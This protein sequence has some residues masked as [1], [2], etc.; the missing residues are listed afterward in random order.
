MVSVH[1]KEEPRLGVRGLDPGEEWELP[2]NIAEQVQQLEKGLQN[3]SP[4]K[5]VSSF[6]LEN[7]RFKGII[8]RI[9]SLEGYEYAEIQEN[10]LS[11]DLYPL[12]LL[13]CKLS[14]FGAERFN[15]KSDKW[16]RITL[17]QGA[18]L[19]EEIGKTYLDHWV[20]PSL[21]I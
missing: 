8:Q 18:P 9:Q 14:F 15:P 6:I 7:P 1:G 10:L 13:R 11:K 21:P 2:L 16:V 19:V 20:F 4:Q 17:F 12:H 5:V 3:E